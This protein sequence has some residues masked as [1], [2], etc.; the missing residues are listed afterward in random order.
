ME[1]KYTVAITGLLNKRQDL[2]NEN[3]RVRE[4]IAVIRNDIEAIDRVL[5]TLGFLGDLEGRTARRKRIVIFYR[6]ELRKFLIETMRAAPGPVSSRYLA[7]R[8]CNEQGQQDEDH[9]LMT[10]LV[11]RVTRAL[12]AM[13]AQKLAIFDPE[14]H[15]WR[16]LI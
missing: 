10:H 1:P 3:A 6:N 5:D 16:L 9:R 8:L 11:K 15:K 7:S 14:D 12:S 13:R 2:L 4:R